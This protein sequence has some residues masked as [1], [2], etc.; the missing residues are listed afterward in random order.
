MFW[1]AVESPLDELLLIGDETRRCEL[2]R[3]QR[4]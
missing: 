2:R 3:L 4:R 1:T